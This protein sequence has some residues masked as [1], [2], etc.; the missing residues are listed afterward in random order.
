[1]TQAYIFLAL[2]CMKAILYATVIHRLVAGDGAVQGA[3][4]MVST[5]N[6]PK[7]K[8]LALSPLARSC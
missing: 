3:G 4:A 6:N 1:M 8:T 2:I 7:P 5:S